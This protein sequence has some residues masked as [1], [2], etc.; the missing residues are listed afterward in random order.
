MKIA[1]KLPLGILAIVSLTWTVGF[2][3]VVVSRHALQESIE[4]GSV[5]YAVAA[6]DEVTRGIHDRI[7]DCL[8]F[9]AAPIVARTLEASNDR[10]NNLPDIEATIDDRDRD[11]IAASKSEITFLMRE[12]TDPELSHHLAAQLGAME[13]YAGCKILGEALITNRYGANV[14]QTERTSDYRQDDETWWQHAWEDGLYVGRVEYDENASV[15]SLGIGIRIDDPEGNPIGVLKAVLCIDFAIATLEA[16]ASRL[17]PRDG[18][19]RSSCV[20]SLL[21]ADGT[22]IYSSR[23]PTIRIRD[24][25]EYAVDLNALKA[26]EAGIVHGRD[27]E[28]EQFLAACAFSGERKG[29]PG[30]GWGVVIERLAADAF[31]PMARLGRHILVVSILASTAGMVA[32]LVSSFSFSRRITHLKNAAISLGKGDLGIRAKDESCDEIGQLALN[33]NVMA[34]Q[35]ECSSGKL[36]ARAELLDSSVRER[37]QELEVEIV[38]RRRAEAEL[39]ARTCDLQ[40]RVNELQC[41]HGISKLLEE[42]DLSTEQILRKSLSLIP[43]A[44]QYPDKTCARI[45]L[46]GRIVQSDDFR[47]TEWKLAAPISLGPKLAGA[48]EV[49]CSQQISHREARPFLKDDARLIRMIAEQLQNV[50]ERRHLEQELT[51]AQKLESVGRLAA[52]IAHEINTPTQYIG[53]NLRFVQEALGEL[54]EVLKAF[55]RLL[56]AVKAGDADDELLAHV[57][58]ITSDVDPEYLQEEARQAVEHSLEG[59]E[60]V[61]G[62]VRGMKEFSHPGG[63][64]RQAVDLNRTIANVLTVSRSEWKYVADL[65]TTYDPNLPLVSCCPRE[66][67]QAILNLIVNAAHAIAELIGDTPQEKG[68][69]TVSTLRSGD[70]VEICVEDT[71]TGIPEE[72]RSKVFDHFFT[73]KEVGTGTGQ[74]LAITHSIVTEKHGGTITFETEVGQGTCF[75][76]RLP[77]TDKPC[78]YKSSAPRKQE[79]AC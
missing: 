30:L 65:A 73:T 7:D 35:L 66:F 54:D 78:T 33:F 6:I 50:V 19:K 17:L 11:W 75:V 45:V 37:T 49:C 5:D 56:R 14:A 43:P 60:Q 31:S 71:G 38:E 76:V 9:A 67:S 40:K 61:A 42:H 15:D 24:G 23:D 28:Q 59:V 26:G 74:G 10:F 77:L 55:D 58:A 52:G 46:N 20:L 12:L 27:G 3:A 64:Q 62:I 57:E 13:R 44:L 48:L 18:S 72:I 8:A 21:A 34:T 25:I 22:I 32:G 39:H 53:D 16:R 63:S 68:I 51:Q 36:Q 69:I 47:E 2:Y 79:T 41:L 4:K 1:Y 70:W 29:Y